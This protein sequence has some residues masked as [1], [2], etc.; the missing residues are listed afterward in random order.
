MLFSVSA[1][2][3]CDHTVKRAMSPSHSLQSSIPTVILSFV[4]ICS[5]SVMVG[6]AFLTFLECRVLH[7]IPNHESS[8]KVQLKFLNP[9]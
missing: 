3:C 8:N 9:F 2:R 4:C 6:V 7:Y 5:L 1:G